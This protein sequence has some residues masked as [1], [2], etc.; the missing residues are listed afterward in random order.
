M[1][2]PYGPRRSRRPRRVARSWW[3]TA[4]GSYRAR[5]PASQHA[6]EEVHVESAPAGRAG[7]RR[8]SQPPMR[9]NHSRRSAKL[10][11]LP[12][13][14]GAALPRNSR[15]LG[16]CA[17]R[18]RRSCRPTPGAAGRVRRPAPARVGG[19]RSLERLDP[20]GI[21]DAVVVEDGD[22]RRGRVPKGGVLG[23]GQAVRAAVHP[24][25]RKLGAVGA[26]GH[27]PGLR[28]ELW[29][30]TTTSAGGRRLPAATPGSAP[31]PPA[32]RGWRSRR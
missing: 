27:G 4:S 28:S 15:R 6:V 5:P 2:Y 31:A 32:G 9:S 11:P 13:F 18:P 19:E 16:S 30:A 25:D 20:A 21:G 17:R 22:D 23:A 14:Q 12:T 1:P 26:G 3:T 7:P 29:S 8:S 10:L 24:A